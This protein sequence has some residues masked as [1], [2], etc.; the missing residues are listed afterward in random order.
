M[1][2]FVAQLYRSVA[3]RCKDFITFCEEH[4]RF[5]VSPDWGTNETQGNLSL[6]CGQIFEEVPFFSPAGT[7]FST[8]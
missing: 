6:C 2:I 8:K 3:V 5:F 7:C 4:R 1:R